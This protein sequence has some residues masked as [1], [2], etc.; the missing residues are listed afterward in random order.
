MI[1]R[2]SLQVFLLSCAVLLALTWGLYVLGIWLKGR[3]DS[4]RIAAR[5]A[6]LRGVAGNLVAASV[7][8]VTPFCSCTTVPFF[9]GTLEAEVPL[10][11]AVSFL[12]AS[13]IINPPA[14]LLMAVIFGIPETVLYVAIC[15]VLSIGGGLLFRRESLRRDLIEILWIPPRS[16]RVPLRE[17]VV[18]ASRAILAAVPF[19]LLASA[20][21]A[22]LRRWTPTYQLLSLVREGRWIAIPAAVLLGWVVHVDIMLLVPAVGLLVSRGFDQGVAFAFLLAASGTGL[23]SFLLLTRVFRIRLLAR[24]AAVLFVLILIAGFAVSLALSPRGTP[25]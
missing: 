25:T 15:F 1:S 23:P 20:A 10:G 24:Y 3:I 2:F 7:G 4:E 11:H 5:L 19:V 18:P 22:L 13:P 17:C 12:I 16:G 21:A 6:G 9:A 14:I 8:A